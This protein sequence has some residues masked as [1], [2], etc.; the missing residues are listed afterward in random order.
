MMGYFYTFSNLLPL[1]LCIVP[2]MWRGNSGMRRLNFQ[3]FPWTFKVRKDWRLFSELSRR[4]GLDFV[5]SWW[6][7]TIRHQLVVKQGQILTH[8]T[9]TELQLCTCKNVPTHVMLLEIQRLIDRFC[10]TKKSNPNVLCVK[11][12]IRILCVC[13]KSD[14][15]LVCVKIRIRILYL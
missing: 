12:R 7:N 4:R 11:N 8:S 10:E 2:W 9:T 5:F 14:L 6:S 3:L 1:C 15:N 13:K